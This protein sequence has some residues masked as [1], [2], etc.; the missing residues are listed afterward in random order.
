MGMAQARCLNRSG[1]QNGAVLGS[2]G[3]RVLRARLRNGAA[4]PKQIEPNE[5]VHER[6]SACSDDSALGKPCSLQPITR[7][8]GHCSLQ[9]TRDGTVTAAALQFTSF[10]G[11]G[12]TLFV[13]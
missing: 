5:V 2:T 1:M 4:V 13:W 3:S 12:G 11:F 9:P 10:V 7:R 8:N 6:C